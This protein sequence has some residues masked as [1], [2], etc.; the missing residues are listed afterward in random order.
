MTIVPFDAVTVF[1]TCAIV[2]RG[3]YKISWMSL[4]LST[5]KA[6]FTTAP[7]AQKGTQDDPNLAN[8]VKA[9][10]SML[11][12]CCSLSTIYSQPAQTELTWAVLAAGAPQG[13]LEVLP[14]EYPMLRRDDIVETLHGVEV[15]DPYRYII[16]AAGNVM[17]D[18]VN[19]CLC[20]QSVPSFVPHDCWRP[21]ALHCHE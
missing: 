5:R 12:L 11:R 8:A 2:R 20:Q 13:H 10:E 14:S 16:S 19:S 3:S 7:R 1:T 17:Y 9:I 6:R 18:I 15:P 21:N 4:G